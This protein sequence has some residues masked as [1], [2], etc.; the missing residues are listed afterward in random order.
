VLGSAGGGLATVDASE[1]AASGLIWRERFGRFLQSIGRDQETMERL[2]LAAISTVKWTED[3]SSYWTI[4]YLLLRINWS[5]ASWIKPRPRGT[6]WRSYISGDPAMKERRK[7]SIRK[8]ERKGDD[9]RKGWQ[10]RDSGTVTEKE[11]EGGCGDGGGFEQ[12][13][14]E[15]EGKK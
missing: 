11:R 7:E 14:R 4:Q 15:W 13:E 10:N 9:E 3:S 8:R 1:D 12:S 6:N 2:R 5:Y